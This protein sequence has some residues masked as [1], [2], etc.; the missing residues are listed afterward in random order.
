LTKLPNAEWL[1][2]R[3]LQLLF[4]LLCDGD[5][6]ARINGGAV[7]NSLLGEPVSDVDVS[8]NLLPDEVIARFS[9]AG[10]KTVP[11]GIEHGTVTAVIEGVPFEITTLRADIETNGR[12][13]VVR[14]GSDW[15][16]DARRRDFTINALYVDRNG[17]VYDPL[18]GMEDIKLR[19]VRFIGE[20]ED[21]IKEDHLRI[22]RFFRFFAWYGRGAPHREGLKACVRMRQSLQALSVERVWKELK[23]LLSAPEPSRAVL[24]MR[25]TGILSIVLPESEKWGID[26]LPR[27]VRAQSEL[28]WDADPLL[29]LMTMI[30]PD[31]GVAEL[32]S[33]RLK[34]SKAEQKRLF[35]WAS[36]TAPSAQI[37]DTGLSKLLYRGSKEGIVD[38]IRLELARLREAGR[39]DDKALLAA[40]A[41][42]RL[43][44]FSL[45]WQRPKFPVKGRDLIARGA[46]PGEEIGRRLEVLENRW[47]ESGFVLGK[48]A[49]LK[50]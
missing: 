28:G 13:A 23:K 5:G 1:K 22:L 49:L 16:D 8:T 46:I 36:S 4:D 14:F 29:R 15:V 32:L 50:Q 38:A 35:D 34:F 7:R 17:V 25:Q 24:W 33:A 41:V 21:R 19:R 27:I 11:T 6:E 30:P 26:A 48:E 18:D 20:A 31:Q 40:A 47:I 43:L 42:N 10:L 2:A 37:S 12:H 45:S 9:A 44:D 39:D 3:R